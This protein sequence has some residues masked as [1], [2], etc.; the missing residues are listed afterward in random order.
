M[1]KWLSWILESVGWMTTHKC[2]NSL[3][4]VNYSWIKQNNAHKDK[5]NI[6]TLI[7]ADTTAVVCLTSKSKL[8]ETEPE[9]HLLYV[10]PD[11]T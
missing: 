6:L 5:L 8:S 11:R 10:S 1:H 2:L 4:S 3:S 9:G 7:S